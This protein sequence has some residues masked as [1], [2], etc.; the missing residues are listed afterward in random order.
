MNCFSWAKCK[1]AHWQT[2][3]NCHSTFIKADATRFHLE[4]CYAFRTV[5]N[6]TVT[7]K[8]TAK[9]IFNHLFFFSFDGTNFTTEP[10]SQYS[11]QYVYALGNYRDSPFVTGGS[12]DLTTEILDY[13]ARTWN[14]ESNYPY[15]WA[16]AYR[17]V[18][19]QFFLQL[20]GFC[21]YTNIYLTKSLF[22]LIK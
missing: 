2:L 14:F 20:K 8:L 1:V 19:Y 11:Y 4:L 22:W 7:R 21:Q 16:N 12:Y 17:Y 10:S 5:I 9:L 6:E 15:S 13:E 3:A 18:K